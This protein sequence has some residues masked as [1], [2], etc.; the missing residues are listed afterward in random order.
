MWTWYGCQQGNAVTVSSFFSV[1]A[2]SA[3]LFG[4]TP[5]LSSHGRERA[6]T[7]VQLRS[8]VEQLH[9]PTILVAIKVHPLF[10][11]TSCPKFLASLNTCILSEIHLDVRSKASR[12][13]Y[14]YWL[15]N[16]GAC[17]SSWASSDTCMC[18]ID[19]SKVRLRGKRLLRG[20]N[21]RTP[22]ITRLS[23]DPEQAL[24]VPGFSM[25]S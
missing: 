21:R 3:A 6:S 9:K 14:L 1:C 10:S 12:Q 16:A 24:S 11:G 22:N 25:F 19:V 18:N 17:A 5:T 20:S 15:K 2:R 7:L 8:F 13:D 23:I 4:V